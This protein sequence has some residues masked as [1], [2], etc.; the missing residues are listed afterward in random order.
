MPEAAQPA[1]PFHIAIDGPA[2]SGK[3]TAARGVSRALG[4]TYIDT[5]AMYRAVALRI[6]RLGSE[7]NPAAWPDIARS[8]TLSFE[9][10]ASGQHVFL[11]GEDVEGLIRSPEMSELTSRVS[12]DPAVRQAVTDA[13]RRMAA[14]RDAVL[15]GRDI[16]TVVLPNAA[17]KIFLKA[18][19]EVR[20]Q[21]RAGDLAN[22]GRNVTP[23]DLVREI[24]ERDERDSTR[25]SAPLARA[26]DAVEIDTGRLDA[27]A[28]VARIVNLAAERGFIR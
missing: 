11:D 2:G 18:P 20:A 25:A 8:A 22:A 27:D 23:A 1:N 6:R 13:M 17:L 14:S 7:D 4:I 24:R 19:E 3:S 10:T 28:V 21:R 16:G 26:A 15:E 9:P 5:G 12:T